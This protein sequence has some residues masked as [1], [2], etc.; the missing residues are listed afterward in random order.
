VVEEGLKF[1][2]GRVGW[3]GGGGRCDVRE[4]RREQRRERDVLPPPCAFMGIA[5]TPFREILTKVCIYDTF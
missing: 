2:W 3:R 1:V 4:R 5:K